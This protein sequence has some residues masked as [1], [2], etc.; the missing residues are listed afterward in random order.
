MPRLRN[1]STDRVEDG[2]AMVNFVA[3]SLM[4]V[5]DNCVLHPLNMHDLYLHINPSG[6]RISLSLSNT[7]SSSTIATNRGRRQAPMRSAV[8]D[9]I[10][11]RGSEIRR[12]S[13]RVCKPGSCEIKTKYAQELPSLARDRIL[14]IIEMCGSSISSL[15]V[16]A[17]IIWAC[18][19]DKQTSS[20]LP[21]LQEKCLNVRKVMVIASDCSDFGQELHPSAKD[22]STYLGLFP[23]LKEGKI[24]CPG[25]FSEQTVHEVLTNCRQLRR[26]YI[27]SHENSK[28]DYTPFP[29]HDTLELLFLEL[30]GL[31]A[32]DGC[33][34]LLNE[35]LSNLFSPKYILLKIEHGKYPSTKYLNS[36]FAVRPELQWLVVVFNKYGKVLLCH[37]D[38]Q[39]RTGVEIIKDPTFHLG[40]L[41]HTYP[42][43]YDIFWT[44]PPLVGLP[45]RPP[46]LPRDLRASSIPITDV[47]ILDI[48]VAEEELELEV[49]SALPQDDV[50][51][52]K[53]ML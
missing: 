33:N 52:R 24:I 46:I 21:R 25:L 30:N 20:K 5:E 36:F 26:L 49:A 22:I 50:H 10:Q 34:R 35:T 12:L 13:I 18:C 39:S 31:S 29:K 45:P 19:N 44:W 43:L 37:A 40:N 7:S 41:I 32:D 23:S 53:E 38:K 4:S 1:Q 3:C 8:A 51:K 15:E 28:I 11:R 9:L 14:P 16:S 2:E 6:E 17:E 42:E 27:I 47:C 48:E